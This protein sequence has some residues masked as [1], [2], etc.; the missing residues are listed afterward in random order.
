MPDLK[1]YFK[2]KYPNL[3]GSDWIKHIDDADRKAWMELMAQASDYG[4]KGGRVRADTGKRDK[5]MRFVS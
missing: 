1:G 4:R 3:S 5:R 2:R